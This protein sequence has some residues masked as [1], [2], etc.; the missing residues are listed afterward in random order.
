MI[1]LQITDLHSHSKVKLRTLFMPL[2]VSDIQGLTP[3]FLQINEHSLDEIVSITISCIHFLRTLCLVPNLG[4][5]DLG[6]KVNYIFFF[7]I[8]LSSKSNRQPPGWQVTVCQLLW[9]PIHLHVNAK[10]NLCPQTKNLN[11][12]TTFKDFFLNKIFHFIFS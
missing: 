4:W 9:L 3:T 8:D 10:H 12:M 11:W 5:V 1:L 2:H 7:K 6:A